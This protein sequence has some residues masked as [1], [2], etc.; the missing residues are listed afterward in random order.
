MK[1]SKIKHS[2]KP[3]R[4]GKGDVPM[5]SS[6]KLG[7]TT[8][9][10]GVRFFFGG[11]EGGKDSYARRLRSKDFKR[12]ECRFDPPA[13]RLKNITRA[14]PVSDLPAERLEEKPQGMRKKVNMSG[15]EGNAPKPFCPYT[16]L[17]SPT[18]SMMSN[19][20]AARRMALIAFLERGED[21]K[22]K[23]VERG[24]DARE[25]KRATSFE[26]DFAFS[27][28]STKKTG[29]CA[30]PPTHTRA[31]HPQSQPPPACAP[32]CATAWRAARPHRRARPRPRPRRRR[33]SLPSTRA[34]ATISSW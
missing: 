3:H 27:A 17:T 11:R 31:R 32:P 15:K 24:V 12:K 13:K 18:A 19:A 21:I 2:A 1:R 34:W 29:G 8:R 22:G 20:S 25:E 14:Q 28:T 26:P 33:C 4:G 16:T 5:Q 9:R 23:G 7:Q 30:P 6:N 10:G